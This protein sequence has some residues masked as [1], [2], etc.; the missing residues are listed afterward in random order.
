MDILYSFIIPHK[1]SPALLQR[2]VNSIPRRNDVQIIVVDDNSDSDIV[3][4]DSFHFDDK[5][6][7]E[8]FI[9]RGG[10]GAGA[11][12]NLGLTHAKGKWLLFADADDLYADGFL[13]I[14][15]RHSGEDLDV[16]YYNVELVNVQ[17][18]IPYKVNFGIQHFITHFKGDKQDI[19]KL[20][21]TFNPPWF[22]MVSSSFLKKHFIQFEDVVIGNDTWYSLQVG[23]YAKNIR[24]I[25]DKLYL[26][27]YNPNSLSHCN[28]TIE[29]DLVN[30]AGVIKK[31]KFYKYI[32]HPEYCTSIL[33][34][35]KDLFL[36]SSHKFNFLVFLLAN[37]RQLYKLRNKYVDG[38]KETLN[39][40]NTL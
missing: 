3:D 24:V 29:K 2:C 33:G 18:L 12:R 7:I 16:L 9:N 13:D 23:F 19:E 30:L 26:Y 15:D 25:Q 32:N 20:R 31:D 35:V 17:T 22:K 5:R 6:C 4:W 21:Y 34:A 39:Y 1:N 40:D 14:L 27:S 11:A 28:A 8:L 38:I 10:H 36:K 37:I